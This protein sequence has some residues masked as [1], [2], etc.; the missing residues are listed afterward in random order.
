MKTNNV[1]LLAALM[2]L[3]LTSCV[4][5]DYSCSCTYMVD[6]VEF[7]PLDVEYGKI[8]ASEAEDMCGDRETLIME[9]NANAYEVSCYTKES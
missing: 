4:K 8:S 6:G 2:S 1:L 3:G 7:A 5:K 9:Q